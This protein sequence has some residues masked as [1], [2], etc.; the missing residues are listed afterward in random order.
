M[1]TFRCNKKREKKIDIFLEL[2]TNSIMNFNFLVKRIFR[3]K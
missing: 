2:F 1:K 3:E